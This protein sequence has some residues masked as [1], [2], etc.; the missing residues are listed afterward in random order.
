MGSS[1]FQN[2]VVLVTGGARGIGRGIAEAFAAAQ[3]TVVVADLDLAE[4][5]AVASELAAQHVTPVSAL[6]VDV[7]D[8][9]MVDTMVADVLARFGRVD[10]L[11]NNAGIYPNSPLFELSETEWDNVFDTNVKGVFLV[12]KAVARVM[13]AQ[14]SGGRIINVSSGAAESARA[15]AAHYCASKSAV[16]MLTK[17]LALELSPHGITVNAI[18]PGLVEV[19]GADL[20]DDYV[21]AIVGATPVGRVGYPSDVANGALFLAAA[22][23]S[24]ISGT[25]L[26][27]DG[28][29]MAGRASLPLSSRRRAGP[30]QEPA[31][32]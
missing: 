28:G 7:G 21:A 3:A 24:F 27:I 15:G 11:V 5:Q 8:A 2:R 17:V 26:G 19:P 12:S 1:D 16:N 9:T 6:A 14:A 29:S 10:V 32:G 31:D 20:T 25:V 30:A 18:S 4:A 23:S 22:A 13:V